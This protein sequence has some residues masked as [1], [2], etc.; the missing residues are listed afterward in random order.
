MLQVYLDAPLWIK[1]CY[2]QF[3]WPLSNQGMSFNKLPII[4]SLLS[5]YT[6]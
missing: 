3:S 5:F 1:G 6:D 2:K 4:N